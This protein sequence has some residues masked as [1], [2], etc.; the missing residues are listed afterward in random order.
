LASNRSCF[1]VDVSVNT[2]AVDR[3]PAR[4]ETDGGSD[5]G[6]KM[7]PARGDTSPFAAKKHQPRM[8]RPDAHSSP[9]S[10]LPS[11]FAMF[12][13][14]PASS[15]AA[16]SARSRV[17]PGATALSAA[18]PRAG[19]PS[20]ANRRLGLVTRADGGSG[21]N[22][23][24]FPYILAR[25]AGFDTSEGI[26]GFTPFAELFIGRT[27]MGGF[28]TGLA[29]ELLTGDGILAQLGWRNTPDPALFDFFIAFLASTTLAGVF[30]TLRQIQ[31]G[32]MSVR[33]F[34]RYQ[35][36]LGLSPRD[37]AER[38]AAA[39]ESQARE[40]DGE[41]LAT[42]FAAVARSAAAADPAMTSMDDEPEMT[43]RQVN[44]AGMEYMKTVE[45]NNARWAM[46]GFATAV[47]ME[48]KTGGGIV[49]QLIMYGKMSGVL[50]ADSGF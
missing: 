17:A 39:R 46:V 24:G 35:A 34:K 32:E 43:P 30:V 22:L 48:A 40:L 9:R 47:V 7:L 42:E 50:G 25:K 33:Q 8:P 31:S 18:V 10:R 11:P 5:D 12:A 4:F 38:E 1:A 37:E 29:Q 26:A 16:L 41:A 19:F 6:R 27:A 3:D 15:S 13:A 28:A 36:F 20:V 2:P 23:S 44:D 21:I 49:P 45:L 14:V